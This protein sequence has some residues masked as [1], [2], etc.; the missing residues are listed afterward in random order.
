MPDQNPVRQ[1]VECVEE[2][3]H[4]A[5][6]TLEPFREHDPYGIVVVQFFQETGDVG[7][8]VLTIAIHHQYPLAV[9]RVGEKAEP[10]ADRPLMADIAF[11]PQNPDRVNAGQ[12]Q[13]P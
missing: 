11:E 10:D 13:V 5:L 1:P 3:K 9:A 2:R 4:Q 6:G 12:G 8:S 7:G